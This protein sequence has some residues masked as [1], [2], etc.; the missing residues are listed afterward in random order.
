METNEDI[1][2]LGDLER[3]GEALEVMGFSTDDMKD[4][5]RMEKVMYVADY[6]NRLPEPAAFVRRAVG[7]KQID[8]IQFMSEY[9]NLHQQLDKASQTVAHLQNEIQNYEK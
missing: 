2:G 4:P 6:L 3:I 8:R 7:S 1:F 9:V 5:K